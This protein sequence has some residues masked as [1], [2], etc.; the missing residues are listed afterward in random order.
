MDFSGQYEFTVYSKNRKV[1]DVSIKDK[2]P[3]VKQY[4]DD[5][6]VQVFPRGEETTIE[7]IFFFLKSRCYE[8]GRADLKEILQAAGMTS[9]DPWEWC[10]KTHGVTY[11]DF[12]WLRFPAD[13][14]LTWEE[15]KI[16]D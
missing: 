4:T 12:Y 16:R 2:I 5:P 8:D 14:D 6:L 7:D 1:A 3:V 10:R 13:G 15:V 11:D 9:N